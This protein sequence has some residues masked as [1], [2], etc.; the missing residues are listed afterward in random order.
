MCSSP[1]PCSKTSVPHVASLRCCHS[2]FTAAGQ[3]PAA[4]AGTH[5]PTML[6]LSEGI[7]GICAP[8][9][10]LCLE[11]HTYFL[12]APPAA[13]PVVPKP[14][15]SDEFWAEGTAQLPLL[16]PP[17][18]PPSVHLL[19]GTADTRAKPWWNRESGASID[20]LACHGELWEPLKEG[21]AFPNSLPHQQTKPGKGSFSHLLITYSGYITEGEMHLR[22]PPVTMTKACDEFCIQNICTNYQHSSPLK[23]LGGR[24]RLTLGNQLGGCTGFAAPQINILVRLGIFTNVPAYV[25]MEKNL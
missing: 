13:H 25:S 20:P 16:L 9:C 8:L 21:A 10:P 11:F 22:S 5:T 6:H 4:S 19:P 14:A 3:R 17:S 18:T 1:S 12:K 15:P 2:A 24:W 7:A 23:A